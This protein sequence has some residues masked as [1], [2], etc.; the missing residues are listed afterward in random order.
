MGVSLEVLGEFNQ[1]VQ[2]WQTALLLDSACGDA[3][4]NI[5]MMSLRN[6]DYLDGWR[7]YEWRLEMGDLKSKLSSISFPEMVQRVILMVR[8]Y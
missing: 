2:S 5:A 1:A 3:H 4:I 8:E 7:E 6:G